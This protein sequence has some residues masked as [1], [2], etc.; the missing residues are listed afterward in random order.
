MNCKNHPDRRAANECAGCGE[1][2]CEECLSKYQG[3]DYC[4]PCLKAEA[5]VAAA[6]LAGGSGELARMKRW[7]IGCSV[8][9]MALVL[10]PMFLLIYPCFSLGDIGRCRG[11]LEKIYEA[12]E[13]YAEQND[14]RFP[15]N[16]ND[17]GPLFGKYLKDSDVKLFH[18]PGAKGGL[19]KAKEM[20]GSTAS[21]GTFPPR[22]SYIYQGGL[23]LPEKQEPPKPLM[24]DRSPGNHRGKGINVLYTDGAVKFKTKGLS[25]MKLRRINTDW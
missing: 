9:L 4:G 3:K 8:I 25:R 17:L 16:N 15:A 12:L 5:A 22:M 18:C 21:R 7:L 19:A 23:S 10:T 2:F 20:R 13:A 14:G 1:G 6:R 11:N 24:W